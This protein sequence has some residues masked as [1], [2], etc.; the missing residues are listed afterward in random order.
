[1]SGKAAKKAR[2]ELRKT[3]RHLLTQDFYKQLSRARSEIKLLRFAV[4][5]LLLIVAFL[6]F[7]II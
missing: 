2:K 4:A 1:M 6:I 3:A 5:G 7:K